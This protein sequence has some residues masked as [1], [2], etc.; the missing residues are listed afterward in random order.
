MDCGCSFPLGVLLVDRGRFSVCEYLGTYKTEVSRIQPL[1]CTGSGQ[2][3]VPKEKECAA[4][5]LPIWSQQI[6]TNTARMGWTATQLL[7]SLPPGHTWAVLD[8]GSDFINP[9]TAI[10]STSPLKNSLMCVSG[11]TREAQVNGCGRPISFLI[12]SFRKPICR[13]LIRSFWKL[14]CF[15]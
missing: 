10:T 1:F 13:K 3:L 5:T 9:S 2:S 11:R 14:W 6:P 8:C 7:S 15:G 12:S 4:L